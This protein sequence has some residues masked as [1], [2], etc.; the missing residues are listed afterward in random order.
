MSGSAKG[1]QDTGSSE[2]FGQY[3]SIIEFEDQLSLG[4]VESSANKLRGDPTLS[5]IGLPRSS[6]DIVILGHE[7]PLGGDGTDGGKQSRVGDGTAWMAMRQ[8]I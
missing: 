2:G 8:V 1:E 7:G 6:A 4:P 5:S 3:L